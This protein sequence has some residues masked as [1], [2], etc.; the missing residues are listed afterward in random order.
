MDQFIP[1]EWLWHYLFVFLGAL[2]SSLFLTWLSIRIMRKFNVMDIPDQ[3]KIHEKPIPRMAGIGMYISFALPLL[4]LVPSDYA[5]RG[6]IIGAG[7]ALAIGAFDDIRG[8]S[9]VV[10]LVSLFLLTILIWRFGVIASF[11]FGLGRHGNEIVNLVLTMLW[12]TGLCS[13]INALDHMDG[14][15]GG[16]SVIAAM[17]Y[18]AVSIQSQQ[19]IWG[20]VSI[21]LIG[22]LL[23]FLFF[24]R[25]PAKIFMG[26]SGSFFLG[27]S[28]AS[29]GIMGG[30]SSNPIKSVIIPIAVLSI[31]IFD[32]CYVIIAR[33]L[34]GTT[35]SLRESIVYCGKDHIGHRL[36]DMGFCQVNSV[37]IVWLTSL[38]VA[39]SAVTIRYTDRYESFLFLVQIIMIYVILMIFMR[40]PGQKN[41]DDGNK[42]HK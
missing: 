42:Q 24:N 40:A 5:E 25:H 23:G 26:D 2:A 9:A 17:S 8:V 3:R 12:L 10:K 1:S 29:I 31:P 19:W 11:N 21:S 34:N 38:T 13:A 22:S 36:M 28:L 15:A 4:L 41:R 30:W 35:K 20:L 6:I 16:V 39:I 14:L 7:I 37:R 18:L 33:R 32:L 27:F